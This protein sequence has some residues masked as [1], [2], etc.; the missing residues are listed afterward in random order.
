MSASCAPPI[1]GGSGST[2]CSRACCASR[3]THK[4]RERA[5]ARSPISVRTLL[6]LEAQLGADQ[7]LPAVGA[8]GLVLTRRRFVVEAAD[9]LD[10]RSD[11]VG[12][13]QHEQVDLV[14][15]D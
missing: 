7:E 1:Q 4:K 2:P 10:A 14:G 5:E 15:T 3:V 13:A 6:R 11:G 8:L 12:A 9:Q